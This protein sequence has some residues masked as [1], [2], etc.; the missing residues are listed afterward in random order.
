[1][2]V[3]GLMDVGVIFIGSVISIVRVLPVFSAIFLFRMIPIFY[4]MSVVCEL[5]LISNI[6]IS[7]ACVTSFF[8]DYFSCRGMIWKAAP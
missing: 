1:M 3:A 2:I 6:D 8:S 4:V 7:V 5:L